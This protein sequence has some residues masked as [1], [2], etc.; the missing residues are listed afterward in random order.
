M[1]V[2]ALQEVGG[3]NPRL[4][5]GEEPD[6]CVRLRG[7]GWR[8]W[9]LDHEMT[10]HDADMT[11]FGQ[12]WKRTRRAGHAFAEGAAMHGAG[13]SGHWRRETRKAVIWG[14]IL[15]LAI[16][17]AALAL[18]PAAFLAVLIYPA[19]ILRLAIREGLDRGAWERALFLV[20]GKFPEAYGV[21][22]YWRDRL[23]GRRGGL[24]EYK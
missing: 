4:I 24:I 15:P 16:V 1:R 22:G 3:F 13:P 5:A 2:R 8:I 9:R 18:G 19:Q 6:L 21:L 14:A 10:L 11:R 7:R 12:W 20:L 23:M 17:I